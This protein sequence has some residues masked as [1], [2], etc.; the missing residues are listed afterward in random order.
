MQKRTFSPS[1]QMPAVQAYAE[2]YGHLPSVEAFKFL[3]TDE[4][5]EQTAR[6]IAEREPIADWRYRSRLRTGSSLDG[7]Y[8]F[9][10]EE[11]E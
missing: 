8:G 10:D 4:L 7:W 9:T 11:S 3:S 2:K 6:A 1:T 5:E